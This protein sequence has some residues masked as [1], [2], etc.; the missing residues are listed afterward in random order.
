MPDLKSLDEDKANYGF[1]HHCKQLKNKF[2]LA[3]CNYNSAKMGPTVPAS[4]C[5][6]DVKIYNSNTYHLTDIVDKGNRASYNYLLK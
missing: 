1:C 3:Q 2:V 4:Y 6:K 5:V